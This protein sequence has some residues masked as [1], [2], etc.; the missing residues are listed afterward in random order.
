[1][2]IGHTWLPETGGQDTRKPKL[3]A[4]GLVLAAGAAVWGVIGYALVY[5]I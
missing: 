1:M 5:W 2:E 4:R 3:T